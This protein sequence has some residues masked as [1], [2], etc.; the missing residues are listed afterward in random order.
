MTIAS[1]EKSII[2]V[3]NKYKVT[4]E[5]EILRK[6]RETINFIKND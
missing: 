6:V 4:V 2:R 3:Q 1:S 5:V